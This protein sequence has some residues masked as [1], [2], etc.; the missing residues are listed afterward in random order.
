MVFN[1]FYYKYIVN[2]AVCKNKVLQ[3][4]RIILLAGKKSPFYLQTDESLGDVHLG[5]LPLDVKIPQFLGKLHLLGIHAM[6]LR[7][8]CQDGLVDKVQR[9]L[10][11]GQLDLVALWRKRD[12][13]F[14]F[15]RLIG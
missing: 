5:L 15:D 11:A 7:E 13:R 1:S 8:R 10:L 2:G 9:H 12:S 4:W 3:I 14:S 6:L